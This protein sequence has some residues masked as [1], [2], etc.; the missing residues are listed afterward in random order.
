MAKVFI[1][2]HRD[3]ADF[4][5]LLQGRL[6]KAGHDTAMDVEILN[7]GDDWRDK[8]DQTIKDSHV[9]V[10]IMTP[11]AGA[12]AYVSYE[13]A[14]AMGAG[15]TIIPLAL[16]AS[17]F[18]PRLE[19]LQYLDFTNKARPWSA[20]ITEVDKAA[21]AHA[22][23]TLSVPANA[24]PSIKHAVSAKARVLLAGLSLEF[25]P[26]A[27]VD[28][29]KRNDQYAIGLFLSAGMDP[30]VINNDG[31]TALIE[32][33]KNN[34][35]DSVSLL[36]AQAGIDLNAI[37]CKGSTALIEAS[38]NNDVNA[39]TLLLDKTGIDPNIVDKDSKTALRYA[40]DE[41]NIVIVNT[42]LQAGANVNHSWTVNWAANRGDRRILQ[43]L[44]ESGAN[45]EAIN[46][47]FSSAA[48]YR[49]VDCMRILR[50]NGADIGSVGGEA[51][52]N[53][54][55][56][57]H[58][59]DVEDE[60]YVVVKYLLK[61]GVN[62]N[63]KDEGGWTPLLAAANAG[64]PKVVCALLDAGADINWRGECSGCGSGGYT[65]LLLAPYDVS[66]I[67]LERGADVN[68]KRNNGDTALHGVCDSDTEPDR[69][70]AFAENLIAM[71]ADVNAK[72]QVNNTPLIYAA[73]KDSRVNFVKLLLQAG[74]QVD[75][76][77]ERGHTAL[78]IAA[79]WH[80][81]EIIK[82]L[83]N[84]GARVDEVDF[85]GNMA[86]EFAKSGNNPNYTEE[87]LVLSSHG[88]LFHKE[89]TKLLQKA[90]V[91]TLPALES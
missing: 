51:L 78:M 68:V 48:C 70:Y 40:V 2:Y 61:L 71:G 7:A 4:A 62:V 39:V 74:A 60:V 91:Q 58:S 38:K 23:E 72:G 36:L 63:H 16:E 32:A 59:K 34:D 88:K 44:L 3:D 41:G 76:K 43:V 35:F 11:Q 65:A 21:E 13:W 20:L 5:E 57:S 64:L 53:A 37:N 14:F 66:E 31:S 10:V 75:H 42:L 79:A 82:L 22:I 73:Y 19:I 90:A 25:T 17:D 49:T 15:L 56:A 8:L 52:L 28:A 33:T 81:V 24:P 89:A 80:N 87:K 67:L 27:F 45:I 86:L 1:S 26:D 55:R 83:L 6:Q 47:A 84:A 77:N 18:H 46:S 54:V 85:Y 29:A 30:N 50:D 69:G 12:S 9:L